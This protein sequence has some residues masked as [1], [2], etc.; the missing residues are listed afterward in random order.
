MR[1]GPRLFGY[2]WLGFLNL[3]IVQ[4]FFV[5]IQAC[6]DTDDHGH[7]FELELIGFILPLTGWWGKYVRLGPKRYLKIWESL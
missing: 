1:V 4:W 7:I 3:L 6:V 2:S 5:R